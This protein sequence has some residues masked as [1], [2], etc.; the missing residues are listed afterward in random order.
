MFDLLL[1]ALATGIIACITLGVNQTLGLWRNPVVCLVGGILFTLLLS[2]AL[3]MPDP[4]KFGATFAF[5]V[6]LFVLGRSK[7]DRPANPQP[8]EQYTGLLHPTVTEALRRRMATS[9]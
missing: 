2:I 7:A 5:G 9:E 1:Y 4:L 3:P 6:L 8:T